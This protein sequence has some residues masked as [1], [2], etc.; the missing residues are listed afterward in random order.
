MAGAPLLQGN[1]GIQLE[2]RTQSTAEPMTEVDV[3]A[4]VGHKPWQV[5][6]EP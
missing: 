6:S 5:K 1:V 3:L 2:R 4:L